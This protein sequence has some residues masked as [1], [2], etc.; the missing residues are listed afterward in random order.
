MAQ[1]V[2]RKRSA[3][4]MKNISINFRRKSPSHLIKMKDLIT[5]DGKDE[6]FQLNK[7]LHEKRRIHT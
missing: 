2:D 5:Y 4:F 1:K 6:M 3:N 7:V